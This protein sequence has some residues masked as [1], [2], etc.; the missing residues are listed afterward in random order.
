MNTNPFQI[1]FQVTPA[2]SS[3]IPIATTAPVA[4]TTTLVGPTVAGATPTTSTT[5]ASA[6]PTTLIQ[7]NPTT[8]TTL[9][10]AGGAAS[11]TTTTVG[12]AGSAVATQQTTIATQPPQP[13][14]E[15]QTAVA[16]VAE[17]GTGELAFTGANLDIA[18]FGLA[19]IFVGTALTVRLRKH[20]KRA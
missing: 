11:A 19:F 13:I 8:S 9:A 12:A 4:T 16:P 6:T 20:R 17:A 18:M 7:L 1:H 3:T 14:T 2:S 15:T 10:S 5:L